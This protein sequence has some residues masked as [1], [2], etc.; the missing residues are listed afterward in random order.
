MKRHLRTV[1]FLAYFVISIA[2]STIK[3]DQ[4][5]EEPKRLWEKS[6]N[7]SHVYL[8]TKNDGNYNDSFGKP[9]ISLCCRVGTF[10]TRPHGCMEIMTNKTEIVQLPVYDTNLTLKN[11]TMS[12]EY[13]NFVILDPCTDGKQRTI[14]NPHDEEKWYLLANGSISMP[15]YPE[16]PILDYRQYCFA[17]IYNHTEYSDQEYSALFCV[18]QEKPEMTS[19]GMLVSVPFLVATYVIYWLLPELRNLHGLTLRGYVGCLAMAYSMMGTQQLRLLQ[20]P[21]G[22]CEALAFITYFSFLASFFWLNIMCFDIWWTFGGFRSLRGNA[23]QR[24]RKKFIIYSIYAWGGASILTIICA[25]MNFVPSVP[26]DLIRPEIGSNQ[27]WLSTKAAVALYFY[28]PMGITVVCNICLFISTAL[29]IERHKKDTAHHLRGSE[30]RRHNDNKQ[31]FNLY[32][33]LFIVMGISWSMEIVSWLFHDVKT[34]PEYVWYL[35]DLTNALQGLI[36][37]IIFVWKKKIKRLLL[38]RLGCRKALFRNST[39][40]DYLSSYVS[41]IGPDDTT[42]GMA[43]Q[44][45]IN[46]SAN[47]RAKSLSDETDT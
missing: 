6:S 27:C 18:E 24:D 36:I 40:S 10:L 1:L 3:S 19:Y 31:W 43:L 5:E 17:R 23:K 15:E 8:E 4:I 47:C 11:I 38:K 42:S 21:S 44:E 35:T 9:N 33:K 20:I 2:G 13:F 12:E 7:I 41:T 29:K 22:I 37:F 30:T 39:R 14:L 45:K 34:V 26:R 28:G 16:Q 46:S 32:L 25:I